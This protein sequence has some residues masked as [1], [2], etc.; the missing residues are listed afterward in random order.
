MREDYYEGRGWLFLGVKDS[1]GVGRVL[2]MVVG[3]VIAVETLDVFRVR[4]R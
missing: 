4:L 3:F 2:G 1:V